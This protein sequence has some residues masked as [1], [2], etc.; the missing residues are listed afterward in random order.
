M[1]SAQTQVAIAQGNNRFGI[2]Q[3]T[4]KVSTSCINPEFVRRI[5]ST[6]CLECCCVVQPRLHAERA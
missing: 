3:V 1:R 2:C 6:M 4:S 5:P